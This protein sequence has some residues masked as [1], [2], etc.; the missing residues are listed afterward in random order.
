MAITL[1]SSAKP[2]PP[3]Q[4]E[5]VNCTEVPEGYCDTLAKSS[6]DCQLCKL[7]STYGGVYG[8]GCEACII[9]DG[10]CFWNTDGSAGEGGP[11]DGWDDSNCAKNGG[12][13]GD[14]GGDATPAPAPDCGN[15]GDPCCSGRNKCNDNTLSC[16]QGDS[17]KICA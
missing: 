16:I 9:A 4:D 6:R 13:P 7:N 2:P 14:G 3:P 10:P 11:Y 5:L 1:T 8:S 15:A 17:G 12:E